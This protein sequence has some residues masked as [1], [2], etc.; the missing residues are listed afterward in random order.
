MKPFDLV[1]FAGQSNMAGRGDVSLAPSCPLEA[2]YEY[3]AISDPASLHPISEPFGLRENRQ[4]AIDDEAKKSGGLV[5]AFVSEYHRLTGRAVIGVSASK[6]G[7]SSAEWKDVLAR[8]AAERF[9]QARAYLRGRGL[10]PAHEFVVW[11]QGETDGDHAVSAEQYRRNMESV[12]AQLKAAGLRECGVIQIGHF[13]RYT[14]ASDAAAMDA[15]YAVIRAEQLRMICEVQEMFFAGSF[16]PYETRMKDAFHYQQ[17]AYNAA[18]AMAAKFAAER[19]A[20]SDQSVHR[21]LE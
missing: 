20:R 3:R 12:W 4:G 7:T 6:G 19:M 13:N 18:G 11:C 21:P 9:A 8:D 14:C 1:L 10:R 15:Q 17:S 16:E 2:G 5:S